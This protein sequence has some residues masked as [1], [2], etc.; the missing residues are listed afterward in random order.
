MEKEWKKL[1]DDVV[2]D[3]SYSTEPYGKFLDYLRKET[4]I[5]DKRAIIKNV[6]HRVKEVVNREENNPYFNFRNFSDTEREL[7]DD[8]LGMREVTLDE[9]MLQPT[10]AEINRLLALNDKL[11]KLTEEC[12]EQCRNLWRTLYHSP[13]KVDDRYDYWLEGVLRYEYADND[14]VLHLENDDYYGSDFD[15]MIHL[16]DELIGSAGDKMDTIVNGT[17]ANFFETE[18]EAMKSLTNTLDDGMSWAEGYLHNKV[19]DKYCI[20][21]AMHALHTHMPWCLPDILRM[22]DFTVS[23]E[24]K[25]DRNISEQRD[26][27]Y[28]DDGNDTD[29]H[30]PENVPCLGRTQKG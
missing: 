20:C 8:L 15:Y 17:C 21:Y 2:N 3:R 9:M 26:I 5:E 12:F 14:S 29:P 18:E 25:Y 4:T 13:Y 16:T 30:W 27:R 19:Y 22:D 23:V 7:L 1:I 6:E 24:L 10:E 28:A 11:Y